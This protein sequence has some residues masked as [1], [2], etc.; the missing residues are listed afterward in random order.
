MK[1][2]GFTLIEMLTC[3]GILGILFAIVLPAVQFAREAARRGKCLSNFRQIGIALNSYHEIHNMFTPD[4]LRTGRHWSANEYSQL[5]FLLPY[6]EQQSLYASIN[7]SFAN[8][9]EP[10]YH[11]YRE[12]HTA[13][14]TRLEAFLCPSDGEAEHTNSYRFNRG[15]RVFLPGRTIDGP[16]SMGVLPS[17]ATVT[18]GLAS[19]AFVSE[20]VAGNF[21]AGSPDP[22]RNIKIPQP[23]PFVIGP[24]EPFISYCVSAPPSSWDYTSGRYWFFSNLSNSHYN[25]NGPPNDP[26]PSCGVS[27]VGKIVEGL[28]PPR[29]FHGG[30]VGVLFGDGHVTSVSDSIDRR[31]WT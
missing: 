17:Q 11:L 7:M 25:H 19:T 20:C 2:R 27:D 26:R 31:V 23:P 1:R 28:M 10:R 14:N 21:I 16:F 5:M 13:R 30:C 3:V 6:L 9:E 8:I 29:S 15:R 4:H 12:N 18:D 24:D 22:V